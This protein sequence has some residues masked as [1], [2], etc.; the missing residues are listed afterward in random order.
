MKKKTGP[1]EGEVILQWMTDGIQYGFHFYLENEDHSSK[2]TDDELCK[3]ME[4][5]ASSMISLL[6]MKNWWR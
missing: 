3:M 5:V 1:E 6:K 4:N 2:L